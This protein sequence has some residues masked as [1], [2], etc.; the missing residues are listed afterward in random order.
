MLALNLISIQ[1]GYVLATNP[2]IKLNELWALVLIALAL[3]FAYLTVLWKG[4]HK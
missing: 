3:L 1:F 4:K 2:K